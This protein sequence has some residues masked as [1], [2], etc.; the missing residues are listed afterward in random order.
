MGVRSNAALV[1]LCLLAGVDPT[2]LAHARPLFEEFQT[3]CVAHQGDPA[4]PL[5]A[6]SQLGW[7][8][9]QQNR[10]PPLSAPGLKINW[11]HAYS[12]FEAGRFSAII[13]GA[14]SFTGLLNDKNIPVSVCMTMQK[15]IDRVGLNR[16]EI[17]AS[18]PPIVATQENKAYLFRNGPTGH[19]SLSSGEIFAAFEQGLGREVVTMQHPSEMMSGVMLVAPAK[20][21]R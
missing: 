5:N 16:A 21:Q 2:S 1:M 19:R 11:L 15:P 17:W 18:V 7:T 3:L 4:G 8:P 20:P 13:S 9:I 6:A 12:H 10:I 14:A